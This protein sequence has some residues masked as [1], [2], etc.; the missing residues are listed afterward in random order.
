MERKLLYWELL[1]AICTIVL[2]SLLHFTYDW[3]GENPLVGAF[4]AMNESVWEHMKLLFVPLFLGGLLQW[5]FLG[6]AYPNF[7]AAR[8]AATLLG[9]LL[10]PTLYYTYTGI[11]GTHVLWADVGLFIVSALAAH[12]LEYAILKRGKLSAPW[13]QLAG[14]LLL[15]GLALAFLYFSFSAPDIPLWQEESA[16]E[17]VK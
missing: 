13:M 10:I 7:L 12:A 9:L 14:L 5:A 6:S 15:L 4:S 16:T 3:S 17:K 1:G 2:G 11:F 8:G